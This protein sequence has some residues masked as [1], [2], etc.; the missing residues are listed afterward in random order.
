VSHTLKNYHSL[1]ILI[2]TDRSDESWIKQWRSDNHTSERRRGKGKQTIFMESGQKLWEQEKTKGETSED[3]R[4]D[5]EYEQ[6]MRWRYR[7]KGYR[8][9]VG[10]GG[11]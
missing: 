6:C 4:R 3:W 11:N 9:L 5:R 2:G 10:R 1:A 7:K 8:I